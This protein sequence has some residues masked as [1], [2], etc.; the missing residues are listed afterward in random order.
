METL[1]HHERSRRGVSGIAR[2]R[3]RTSLNRLQET[4]QPACRRATAASI[5]AC[6]PCRACPMG[7]QKSPRRVARPRS[8]PAGATRY[9]NLARRCGRSAGLHRHG[10][11]SAPRAAPTHGRNVPARRPRDPDLALGSSPIP[12]ISLDDRER[13]RRCDRSVGEKGRARRPISPNS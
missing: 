9:P 4:P 5:S 8:K 1:R 3:P 7:E 6:A 11:R 10:C 12:Q 13:L 2:T